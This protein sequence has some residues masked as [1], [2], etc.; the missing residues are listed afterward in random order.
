MKQARHYIFIAAL[1]LAIGLLF[2]QEPGFGDDL[3]YWSQAFEMLER[4]AQSIEKA[5]F[6]DLRWPV[7]GVCWVIQSVAGVGIGAFYGEPLFYLVLGA[8]LAFGLGRRLMDSTA[9]GYSASIAFLFHPLLD[10]VCF[11][12][13]P[14]LSEGVI[15]AATIAAWWCLVN[16]GT[17]SRT[18]LWVVLTGALV[19]TAQANRVT[20]AFIV[21]VLIA[22]T[23]LFFPRKFFW[24]VAAGVVAI[25]CYAGEA[26]IYHRLFGDWMHSIHANM[27]NAGN[28]GTDPMPLWFMPIRFLDTLWSGSRI[29]PAYCI[30]TVIGAVHTWRKFGTLGRVVVVWAVVL[31]LEY[32]CAPQ[33]MWPIRPLIRDADRFLAGLAVP[34]S[35][36]AISGLFWLW[37]RLEAFRPV[38]IPALLK[39]TAAV[40]LLILLTARGRFDLGFVPEFRAYMRALPEHTHIFTH[41]SM[42]SI[43]YLCDAKT[44]SKM[45]FAAPNRILHRT[46]ELERM[47]GNATEFWY[48]RKLVWLS[49]RKALEKREFAKQPPLGS[50]FDAPDTQ[51]SLTK[52]LAKG[53]TPDLIFYR[54]RSATDLVPHV[55]Q[56]DAA[57]FAGLTPE[58]P[59]DWDTSKSGREVRAKWEVP[60]A[61]RG[62]LARLE[63]VAASEQVEAFTLRLK[64][65]R[66]EA[67]LAEYLLKPYLYREGGKD[68]FVFTVP[69]DADHCDFTLKFSP[70]AKAV[71]FTD[72]RLLLEEGVP[73]G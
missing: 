41:E 70:K 55:L 10:S 13:M 64:F 21:P 40:V 5:S 8:M 73:A 48:A 63:I 69:P 65:K 42:R 2:L 57:E 1:A 3:T 43:A 16:A 15:G 67:E 51:W 49:A 53:D 28:K 58:L 33:P 20:G 68:F 23:L 25:V 39:G 37:A 50:Y 45:D 60:S 7:W 14:D 72:F 17:R 11:R 18:L 56:K 29:A 54:R 46:R 19:F 66:A 4:G 22:N 59:Y 44:A 30:L 24:L 61:I 9:A 47:A 34:I 6:H 71:Q 35:L 52:L 38:P 26:A 36:L 32:S 62:K 12:P 31:Y 27:S